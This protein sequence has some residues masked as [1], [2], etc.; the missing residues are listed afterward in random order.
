M[1]EILIIPLPIW[2][3]SENDVDS[4]AQHEANLEKIWGKKNE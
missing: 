2:S 3:T 1:G 4:Q